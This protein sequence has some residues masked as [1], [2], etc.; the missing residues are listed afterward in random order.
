MALKDWKK[1]N[2]STILL[3]RKKDNL[4]SVQRNP[5]ILSKIVYDV[6]IKNNNN[7]NNIV[8]FHNGTKSQALTFAKQYMKTH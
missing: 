3:W 7:Y 1:V 4:L 5:I 2:N 8:L 6:Y